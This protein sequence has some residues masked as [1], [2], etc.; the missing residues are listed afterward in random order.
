MRRNIYDAFARAVQWLE[1]LLVF[2]DN[3][4]SSISTPKRGTQ[5]ISM[6]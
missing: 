1:C 6:L 3:M 2:C 4:R 5:P